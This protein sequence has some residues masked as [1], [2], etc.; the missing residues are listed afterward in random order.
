M[1]GWRTA[2]ELRGLP[3]I[4]EGNAPAPRKA[5]MSSRSFANKV[6]ERAMLAQALSCFAA[7]AGAR[8]RREG[9][10]AGGM[11]VHIRTSRHET[12]GFTIKR[13]SCA[14]PRPRRTA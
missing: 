1:A 8:L 4:G 14:F 6:R 3:C 9:L 13:S 2:L 5:L 12:R 7:R 10:V 11:A